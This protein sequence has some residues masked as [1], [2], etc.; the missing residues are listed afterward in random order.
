MKPALITR[1]APTAL[2]GMET[3]HLHGEASR[4]ELLQQKSRGQHLPEEGKEAAPLPEQHQ[5]IQ[6]DCPTSLPPEPGSHRTMG[7]AH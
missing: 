4:T 6:S 3:P 5:R 1:A 7:A 2:L